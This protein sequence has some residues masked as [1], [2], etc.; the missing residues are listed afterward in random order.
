[1]QITGMV[2]LR[3]VLLLQVAS[4]PPIRGTVRSAESGQ[5]LGF[6][7]VT[8]Q[9]NGG[10]Q[11]TD[12]SGVFAFTAVKPGP[13]ILSVRQIGYAPLDTQ[14]VATGDSTHLQITLRRL[15]IELPP[16]TIAAEQCTN[17]GPPDPGNAS[18]R[19][20]F[21]Q[22]QENARRFTL[23]ADSYPFRYTLELADRVLTQRGD[24]GPPI[25]KRL[26]FS[27]QDKKYHPYAVGRV[28][29]RG[30]GPWGSPDK[31][32]VIAS[33]ELDDLG[34]P[35]FIASHCFGL[36]GRD[37]LG[38][39]T[40]I[41]L[42]FEPSTRVRSADMAGSAYL[43]TATYALRYTTTRLTKPDQSALTDVRAVIFRTRF[44]EIAPGVPLQDS[45]VA[46]TTYRFGRPANIQTQRT[47]DVRF[48]RPPPGLGALRPEP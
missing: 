23:L 10:K 38:G 36:A 43:D 6:S 17:P 16:V 31:T 5:P 45:L 44:R 42:D 7:I 46:F 37:T 29:E 12:G 3:A 28:V 39:E 11:F 41:R 33:A 9:P 1:M 18:L 21:E 22:L 27:S 35:D 47:L 4:S 25:T 32:L 20:V 14:L 8:L 24:T 40:F 13:Y 2:L 48:K 15:A 34:N 19:A 30:W 26:Y